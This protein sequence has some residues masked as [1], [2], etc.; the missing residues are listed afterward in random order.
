MKSD[1]ESAESSDREDRETKSAVR[2]L[3]AILPA[4]V[5][6]E[7]RS[8]G[9][10]ARDPAFLNGLMDHASR[11]SL[12]DP[13]NGRRILGKIIRLR[14]LLYRNL[15]ESDPDVAVSSTVVREE[16]RVGRNDACPC[17]SGRKFKQC[18]MRKAL[19]DN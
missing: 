14:K 13:R 17:G 5:L 12:A 10:D 3:L 15:R 16:K 1:C 18:C 7:I 6:G 9:I 2:E 4:D 19:Q 8:G 11:L